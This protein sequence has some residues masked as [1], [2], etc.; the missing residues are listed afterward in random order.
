MI[1]NSSPLRL[2]TDEERRLFL[3]DWAG[4]QVCLSGLLVNFGRNK[5]PTNPFPIAK[6]REIE[7][8]LPNRQR[9]EL[10]HVWLQHSETLQGVVQPGSHFVCDCRV[11]MYMSNDQECWGLTYPNKVRRIGEP[12]A[13]ITAS[14]GALLPAPSAISKPPMM[15]FLTGLKFITSF[16]I[17]RIEEIRDLVAK[18]ENGW[19]D[20]EKV[21]AF[22]ESIGGWDKIEEVVSL[23]K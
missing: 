1:G 17:E 3:A 10:D 4:Q 20:L 16:Q 2:K 5:N 11:K 14:N 21:R 23:L 22:A 18:L 19:D 12:T 9:H 15:D 6:V 13:M 7:I 8:T